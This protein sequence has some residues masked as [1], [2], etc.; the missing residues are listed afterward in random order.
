MFLVLVLFCVPGLILVLLFDCASLQDPSEGSRANVTHWLRAAAGSAAACAALLVQIQRVVPEVMF[1]AKR[2][3]AI[4]AGVS[5]GYTGTMVLLAEYWR[6][7]IPFMVTV[8]G[9]LFAI[10]QNLFVVITIGTRSHVQLNKYFEH[11][12]S[13]GLQSAM[14]VVYPAYHTV[15][16]SLHGHS[17][18]AFVLVLPMI[19]HAFKFAMR[20]LRHSEDDLTIALSASVDMFDALYTIKCMQSIDTLT[21]GFAIIGVDVVLNLVAIHRLYRQTGRT[22]EIFPQEHARS[23]N[24]APPFDGLL[25]WACK[26]VEATAGLDAVDCSSQHKN[27]NLSTESQIALQRVEST[28]VRAIE[29][30]RYS[31]RAVIPIAHS[32][33]GALVLVRDPSSVSHVAVAE[34]ARFLHV[35]ES[36]AVVEYIETVV[37]VIYAIYLMIIFQLPNAKYYPDIHAL[38]DEKLNVV[39]VNILLYAFME[40]LT[41]TFVHRKLKRRFGISVFYQLA[42]TLE[43]EGVIFQ[44]N[45]VTWILL[46]FHFLLVHNGA[47]ACSSLAE[48]LEDWL[49]IFQHFCFLFFTY[50]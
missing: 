15:F 20:K 46:V 40:L 19:K 32:P 38:T 42:F 7:P 10:L 35:S 11:S 30:R 39:V 25:S 48:R 1:T 29:P 24:P 9:P 36:V 23:Q 18:L 6:F 47:C 3:V 16:L 21:V 17:Q 13:V 27:Y 43:N 4:I 50:F 34:T 5:I 2:L 28:K 12:R 31:H 44:C 14:L 26:Q 37:P 8:G 33:S 45:F 22:R 49:T 41:L